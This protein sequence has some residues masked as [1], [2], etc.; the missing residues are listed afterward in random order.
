M[1]SQ[2]KVFYSGCYKGSII[3]S[4]LLGSM[5]DNC[6]SVHQN[7]LCSSKVDESAVL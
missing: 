4:H 7:L 3:T 6:K 5:D 1:N 2:K